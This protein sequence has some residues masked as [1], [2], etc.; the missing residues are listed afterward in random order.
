MSIGLQAGMLRYVAAGGFDPLDLSPALWYDASDSSTLY[1][2]GG[3]LV[4]ADGAVAR[5]EDKSGNARHATQS[6]SGKRPLRKT[7][8]VNSLDVLRF[9]GTDDALTHAYDSSGNVTIFAVIVKRSTQAA[10]RTILAMG[11]STSAGTSFYANMSGSNRW[12][13]YSSAAQ[14]ATTAISNNVAYLLTMVDSSASGQA[15]YLDGVADGT[16]T[17][18][19]IGESTKNVGGAGSTFLNADFAEILVYPSA[20]GSADRAAVETYLIDKWAI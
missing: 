16:G 3:S 19:T 13:T 14:P 17:G 6:T 20:L 18:N 4:A 1:D 8:I 9:D 12:G 15:F 2:A 7:S 5:W 10:Y 11:A